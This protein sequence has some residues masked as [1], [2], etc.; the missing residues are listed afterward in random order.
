MQK[1][2]KKTGS[3]RE[4]WSDAWFQMAATCITAFLCFYAALWMLQDVF[5]DW[6]LMHKTHRA[7]WAV[8]LFTAGFY[9]VGVRLAPRCRALFRLALAFGYVMVSKEGLEPYRIDFEDGACAFAS[10]YLEKWNVKMNT[11]WEIWSGKAEMI[12]FSFSACM[13]LA[14]LATLCLSMC[15]C[16][17]VFLLLLPSVALCAL[18]L[19]GFAPGPRGLG[20]FLAAAL[21][22]SATNAGGRVEIWR[23][24]KKWGKKRKMQ[25][26]SIYPAQGRRRFFIKFSRIFVPAGAAAF[27]IMVYAAICIVWD[28]PTQ[29]FLETSKAAFQFQKT[30]ERKASQISSAFLTQ[31]RADV[32]NNAPQYTGKEVMRVTASQKPLSSMYL[33]GFCGTQYQNGSWVYN[34]TPFHDACEKNGWGRQDMAETL[35]NMPYELLKESPYEI[36]RRQTV[37]TIKYT[38]IWNRFAYIPY[39]MDLSGVSDEISFLG[40]GAVQKNWGKRTMRFHG[41]NR[42]LGYAILEFAPKLND[43]SDVFLEYDQFADKAYCAIPK[44]LMNVNTD[45]DAYLQMFEGL[46]ES[47]EGRIVCAQFVCRAL[48]ENYEYSLHLDAVPEGEDA[49]EYFL[50]VSGKGYCVHFASAAAWMLKR[51]GVPVRYASGYLVNFRAFQETEDGYEA[52]VKDEDAH[53]WVEIYLK[54]IGW[55]PVDP[56]PAARRQ[57]AHSSQGAS[58]AGQAV[59]TDGADQKKEDEKK[60]EEKKPDEEETDSKTKENPVGLSGQKSGRDWM[61][62]ICQGAILAAAFGA[63]AY[64]LYRLARIYCGYPKKEIEKGRYAAAVYRINRRIRRRLWLRG[65]PIG[66]D[67]TDAAYEKR[68]KSAFPAVSG[69]D[70]AR[71]MESAKKAVFSKDGIAKEDARFCYSIYR[72]ATGMDKNCK[73]GP[74]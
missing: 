51:C 47:N 45:Y 33:K 13:M 60:P 17:R 44:R 25:A 70:W 23:Y 12:S 59:H 1:R 16:R 67:L 3:F 56:T 41:I 62:G 50:N 66:S 32:N 58:G 15:V 9:E 68:L 5:P 37:V 49:V 65:K 61:R 19:V 36:D 72:R 18:L 10:Q 48:K 55:I 6:E 46:T 71:F 8:I 43:I 2:Q 21:F 24:S 29:G 31:K 4:N 38:G 14:L 63:L 69:A 11:D 53:A 30:V 28:A 42:S 39:L 22:L 57:A 52:S 35:L 7:V 34:E 64:A 54:G 20:L 74:L 40:D 27:A 73:T 26:E